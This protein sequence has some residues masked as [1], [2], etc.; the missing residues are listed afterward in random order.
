ME[1]NKFANKEKVG[2]LL[3]ALGIFYIIF[4]SVVGFTDLRIWVDEIFSFYAV[5]NSFENMVTII[6]EDVHPILYY[7]I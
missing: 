5:S 2:I 1:F 7:L 6:V 4:I 3:F